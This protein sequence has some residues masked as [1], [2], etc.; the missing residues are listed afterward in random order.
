M[1]PVPRFAWLGSALITLVLAPA[2]GG[3]PGAGDEDAAPVDAADEEGLI[4]L[5]AR[6]WSIP[7][8]ERYKCIRIQVE[9][10]LYITQFRALAPLGTHHTVLSV[11]DNLGF[12]G[13]SQ[14][15]EYDC[16]AGNLDL[17][18]LYASG[19]G[20]SDLALPDGVAIKVR[21]GQYVNLNLHLFNTQPGS[22]LTGRSG[23]LIK[24]I[25]AAEVLHEAE[26]I[27]AGDA[28][29]D[30]PGE[31]NGTPHR[32]FYECT[33]SRNA[34][35]FAYWPH[36]HQYAVH[37]KVTF[38]IDGAVAFTHDEPYSFEEQEYYPLSPSLSVRSGDKVLV[39][40]FYENDTGVPVTFGDSSDKEM[41]FTGLY[42]YPKQATHLFECSNL[43]GG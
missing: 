25:P 21:A 42:R 34:T 11:A 4:E 30:I 16:Q 39:E 31:T 40:C 28:Q 5:I 38:T 35:I 6:D 43:I 22:E 1:R 29:L 36:M 18:M 32:E 41:C 8:G 23:I 37:Q 27:F 17:Q 12:P 10:D 20:T 3:G 7:P 33:F 15:G 14:L 9:E 19:V 13:G 2:C 26:M 24:A